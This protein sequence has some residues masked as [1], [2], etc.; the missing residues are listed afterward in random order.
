MHAL[1]DLVRMLATMAINNAAVV[2]CRRT[3]HRVIAL[4]V[5]QAFLS[6]RRKLFLQY[7]YKI[8]L[9]FICIGTD[10]KLSAK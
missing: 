3:A 7:L 5:S 10:C 6:T 2:A 1:A 8:L 9:T 4:P